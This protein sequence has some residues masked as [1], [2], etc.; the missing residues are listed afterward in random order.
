MSSA[1][2]MY[3]HKR[4]RSKKLKF[5]VSEI[6]CNLKFDDFSECTRPLKCSN[7]YFTIGA[8]RITMRTFY[9]F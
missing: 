6:F 7:T 1:V 3:V 2:E 5:T 8:T 4:T 9:N